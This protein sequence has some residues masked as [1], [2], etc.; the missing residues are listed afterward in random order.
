MGGPCV[1]TKVKVAEGEGRAAQSITRHS[2]PLTF[3]ASRLW[4][5]ITLP[6]SPQPLFFLFDE[7]MTPQVVHS[8]TKY[9]YIPNYAVWS[10]YIS[11]TEEENVDIKKVALLVNG[12]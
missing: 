3:T 1:P 10:F 11:D 12:C 9:I 8:I 6:P 5:S 7:L 4:R 2:E